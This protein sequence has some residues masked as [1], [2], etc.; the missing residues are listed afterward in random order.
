MDLLQSR[1]DGLLVLPEYISLQFRKSVHDAELSFSL[2][3]FR[4]TGIREALQAVDTADHDVPQTTFFN[5]VST[6]RISR[7][8]SWQATGPTAPC[9]P[10]C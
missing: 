7:L 9:G 2:R 8:R 6:D 5:L 1:R 3:V 4:Q 10:T